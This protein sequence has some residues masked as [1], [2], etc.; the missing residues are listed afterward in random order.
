MVGLP[1]ERWGDVGCAWIVADPEQKPDADDLIAYCATRLA[2]F[3]VPAVV[4][5][6]DDDELPRTVT[7]RVQK[8]HLVNRA[9]T[10]SARSPQESPK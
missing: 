1:H 2:R 6:I 5:F 7:G 4:H 8:F 3:K 9:A 10:T